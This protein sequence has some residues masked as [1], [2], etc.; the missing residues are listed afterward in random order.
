MHR[1]ASARKLTSEEP[2]PQE[3]ARSSKDIE[4]DVSKLL[5]GDEAE[6]EESDANV[7]SQANPVVARNQP[8]EHVRNDSI[9]PPSRE[10]RKFSDPDDGREAK[11]QKGKK[12][13][14]TFQDVEST[15]ECVA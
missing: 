8:N 5:N 12:Q 15:S 14:V 10:K 6:E 13:G 9:K 4:K 3:L 11:R 2:S 1:K 7:N